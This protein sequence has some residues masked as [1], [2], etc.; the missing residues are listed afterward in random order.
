ME[1]SYHPLLLANTLHPD[2]KPLQ[3]SRTT[4]LCG[5][6]LPYFQHILG[7]LASRN[8]QLCLL[9]SGSPVGSVCV[10]SSHAVP[11]KLYPGK[12]LGESGNLRAHRVSC[13]ALLSGITVPWCL[14]YHEV[15]LYN[16]FGGEGVYRYLGGRVSWVRVNPSWLWA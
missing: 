9:H 3:L 13:L 11:C 10:Q 2:G 8:S 16:F 12:K 6:P 14:W 15:K 4:S 5:S 1:V 7:T